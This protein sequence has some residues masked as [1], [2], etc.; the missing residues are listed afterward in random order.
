MRRSATIKQ[1]DEEVHQGV[2]YV[3]CDADVDDPSLPLFKDYPQKKDGQREFEENG[4]ADVEGD[5]ERD[6]LSTVSLHLDDQV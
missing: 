1:G 3:Y 5:L 4:C 2:D 6:I